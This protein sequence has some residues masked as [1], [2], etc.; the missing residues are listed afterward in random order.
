MISS[1]YIRKG[2]VIVWVWSLLFY[3]LEDKN[4]IV[5]DVVV[6]KLKFCVL[7]KGY[8]FRFLFVDVLSF[9]FMVFYFRYI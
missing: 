3:V 4:F 5:L 8:V 6:N 9:Y 2:D 1:C 7:Y